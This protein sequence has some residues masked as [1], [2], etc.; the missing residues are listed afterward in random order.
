M[1]PVQQNLQD[2]HSLDLRN[3]QGW[4]QTSHILSQTRHLLSS[5]TFYDWNCTADLAEMIHLTALKVLVL[6]ST[7]R[8]AVHGVLH[9]RFTNLEKLWVKVSGDG[10]IGCS[11][12]LKQ[13]NI[14]K[15]RELR[16]DYWPDEGDYA[17]IDEFLNHVAK[18]PS[19]TSLTS[20]EIGDCCEALSAIKA[21]RYLTNL[22][23]LSLAMETDASALSTL[24]LPRL[25]SLEIGFTDG[26]ED[27][28]PT[29]FNNPYWTSL[30]KLHASYLNEHFTCGL[31]A[32]EITSII[33][34]ATLTNLKD[35]QLLGELST[36]HIAQL[37]ATKKTEQLTRLTLIDILNPNL[38]LLK[39]PA[40]SI[41][42]LPQ[43]RLVTLT[44]CSQQFV[45]MIELI[46]RASLTEL[47]M[48]HCNLDDPKIGQ[49]STCASLER[50]Q[51]FRAPF[52]AITA[53]G[54]GYITGSLTL[55]SLRIV[56]L[57]ENPIDPEG[58]ALLAAWM[59]SKGL[60][61]QNITLPDNIKQLS[62]SDRME[63]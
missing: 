61:E 62:L 50:L 31:K 22:K 47:N 24:R 4:E 55:G 40:A 16:L 54:V 15:L 11:D 35:L 39:L 56:D 27:P 7:D 20:L 21:S 13:I 33:N 28:A 6:E 23:R 63:Q 57:D 41:S 26:A 43:S 2:G 30:Q 9:M 37:M 58:I 8:R 25:E 45:G 18:S 34:S 19:S 49:L 29:A 17:Y 46:A 32:K 10:G 48:P 52:N 1:Q 60:A 53:R 59:A 36:N 14:P 51:C 42:E 44:V 38:N 3:I 5:L 12:I